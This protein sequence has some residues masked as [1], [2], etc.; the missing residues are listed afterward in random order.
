MINIETKFEGHGI[1][2]TFVYGDLVVRH[3]DLVWERLSHMS[4]NRSKVWFMIEDFNEITGNMRI[5]EG[6]GVV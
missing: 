3:R 6:E 1:F 4:T 5:G 2:M